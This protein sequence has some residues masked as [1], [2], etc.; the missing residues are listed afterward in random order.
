[1]ADKI[2]VVFEDDTAP[3]ISN[4]L[5]KYNLEEKEG[6]ASDKFK[7][8]EDLQGRRVLKIVEA[9]TSGQE[10]EGNLKSLLEKQLAI[11]ETTAQNL[12][13]DVKD[14][15]LSIA[16]LATPEEIDIIEEEEKEEEVEKE[17]VERPPFEP[18]PINEPLGEIPSF[19]NPPAPAIKKP[20]ETAAPTNRPEPP[21]QKSSDTYRESL[22]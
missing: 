9:I 16:R 11:P 20:T 14:R 15:L 2:L 18:M 7:R 21:K 1:M 6:E 3:I 4:I 12:S 8:G 10:K 5:Q 17:S 22:E 13:Q 19:E